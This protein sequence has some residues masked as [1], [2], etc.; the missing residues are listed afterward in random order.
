MRNSLSNLV[1]FLTIGLMIASLT[2]CAAGVK[3]TSS[4]SEKEVSTLSDV[5]ESVQKRMDRLFYAFEREDIGGFMDQVALNFLGDRIN[6][7][8]QVDEQLRQVN[9]IEFEYFVSRI[10]PN[11]DHVDISFRW[12]RRWYDED[13]GNPTRASGRTTFRFVRH[14]GEWKLQNIEGNQPFFN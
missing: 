3:S 9:N 8:S 13:T 4:S 5:R 1:S 12:D 11:Q 7:E 2:A 10:I 14:S 6:L